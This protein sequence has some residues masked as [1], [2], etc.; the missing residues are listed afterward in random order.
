LHLVKP[1]KP[2]NL[3]QELDQPQKKARSG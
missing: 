2:E 1:V 3:L